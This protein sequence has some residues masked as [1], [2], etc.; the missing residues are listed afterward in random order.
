M[1][2]EKK[3]VLVCRENNIWT[4]SEIHI[5]DWAL[6]TEKTLT[7]QRQENTQCLGAYLPRLP[8]LLL[9]VY[10]LISPIIFKMA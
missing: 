2:I 8:H 3:N 4:L 1:L 6:Q 5:R 9:V 7:S 10:M